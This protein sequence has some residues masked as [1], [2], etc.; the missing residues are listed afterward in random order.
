MQRSDVVVEVGASDP[1]IVADV[2]QLVD[3]HLPAVQSTGERRIGIR[4][5]GEGP[6]R[7]TRTDHDRYQSFD[8]N[9]FRQV[10]LWGRRPSTIRNRLD[11]WYSAFYGTFVSS[12]AYAC[13]IAGSHD[14]SS[15]GH[16]VS[17][18]GSPRVKEQGAPSL[19]IRGGVM[20]SSANMPHVLPPP[21]HAGRRPIWQ[22]QRRVASG[23]QFRN[24]PS[25]LFS[26]AQVRIST[27]DQMFESP[28][29]F[30]GES[31]PSVHTG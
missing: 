31:R 15:L 25:N 1:P 10:N 22:M 29:G 26:I 4:D 21:R 7:D 16:A 17:Y 18:S 12:S 24:P 19:R 3:I 9:G 11:H 30:G 27:F 14:A 28:A 13:A 6:K 20:A 2:R 23:S 8:R 5:G